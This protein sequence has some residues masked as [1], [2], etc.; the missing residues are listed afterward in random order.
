M[1]RGILFPG[2]RVRG[3]SGRRDGAAGGT[4]RHVGGGPVSGAC[5]AN[6]RSLRQGHEIFFQH[7]RFFFRTH[8]VE[9]FA[10][11]YGS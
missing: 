7:D 11:I 3:P 6:P 8:S 10:S 5:A 4:E 9:V 2:G 1:R